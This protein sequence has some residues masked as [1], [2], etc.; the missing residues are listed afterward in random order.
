MEISAKDASMPNQNPPAACLF[1][2]KYPLKKYPRIILKPTGT[3]G[4]SIPANI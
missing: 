2:A 1:I 3:R 4:Y